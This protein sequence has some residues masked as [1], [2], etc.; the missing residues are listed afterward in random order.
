M[1]VTEPVRWLVRET[2]RCAWCGTGARVVD[3]AAVAAVAGDVVD[4]S[5]LSAVVDWPSERFTSAL[6]QADTEGYPR[7]RPGEPARSTFVHAL[8]REAT[9]QLLAQDHRRSLH[10]E[11][12]RALEALP[13]NPTRLAE[14]PHHRQQSLPLGDPAVMVDRTV[15]AARAA[16]RVFAYAAVVDACDQALAALDAYRV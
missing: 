3:A 16:A 2:A 8:L 1:P 5:V 9:A 4:R 13:M 11:L 12:A 14:G 10:A 15:D 6:R 7:H